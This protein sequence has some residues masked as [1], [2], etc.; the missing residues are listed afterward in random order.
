MWLLVGFLIGA[1]ML[2][3]RALPGDWRLWLA[4]SHAH[5]LF[6]GWFLQFAIGIAYWLLPRRRTAERGRL[7][8]GSAWQPPPSPP[9][10]GGLICRIVAEPAERTGL[11]GDVTVSLLA[12]SAVLQTAAAVIFAV[13]LW[14]RVAPRPARPQHFVT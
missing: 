9:S 4:P 8:I 5:M 10:T 11:G 14:R 13:Q 2:V 12:A 1:A 6:V 3:D 7:A